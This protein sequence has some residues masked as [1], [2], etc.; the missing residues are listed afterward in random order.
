MNSHNKPEVVC[1]E[2]EGPNECETQRKVNT[3]AVTTG[4]ARRS[5]F[6]ACFHTT[7]RKKNTFSVSNLRVRMTHTTTP[8]FTEKD[9]PRS[10]GHTSLEWVSART[11]RSERAKG[12]HWRPQHGSIPPYK[13]SKRFF[14]VR[15]T[16]QHWSALVP[17]EALF[18]SKLLESRV[19]QRNK[20]TRFSPA[21][22]FRSRPPRTRRTFCPC[23]TRYPS[24]KPA[25]PRAT[26]TTLSRCRAVPH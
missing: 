19:L 24:L 9:R 21:A 8:Q 3:L 7:P 5:L 22:L 4:R 6:G 15:R 12:Y 26:G 18:L 23:S 2:S 16:F 13:G 11:R 1:L 25:G 17:P 20:Y 14:L 10:G